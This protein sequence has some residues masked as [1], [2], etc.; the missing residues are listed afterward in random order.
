MEIITRQVKDKPL[1]VTVEY[2][3]Y[4]DTV[5]TILK[6]IS[7]VDCG[8]NAND[9]GRQLKITLSEA[10]YIENV[11]RKTFI[12]TAKDVY[13]LNYSMAELEE[14]T[15]DTELIRISR[16]CIMNTEHLKEIRQLKNSRLEAVLDN[17]EIL[18]VSRKYLKDIKRAFQK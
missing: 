18:I 7:S 11:E 13:R 14:M 8:F 16:T 17:D 15:A 9:E 4:N 12:Y 6:K 10:Y 3:E 1:T 2:P 5:T